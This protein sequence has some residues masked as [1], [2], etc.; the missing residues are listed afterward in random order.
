LQ[1]INEA[2]YYSPNFAITPVAKSTPAIGHEKIDNVARLSKASEDSQRIVFVH[3]V[4]YSAKYNSN[5]GKVLTKVSGIFYSL[6][7][8]F[9]GEKLPMII[10]TN[11]I[12]F[13]ISLIHQIEFYEN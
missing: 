9:L 10:F 8:E 5:R 7:G 13:K 4:G 3:Q 6:V 12:S 2:D 1:T 11:R